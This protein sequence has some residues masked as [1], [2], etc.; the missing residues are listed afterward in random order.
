MAAFRLIEEEGTWDFQLFSGQF[1]HFE[2]CI[3]LHIKGTMKY[4][5]DIKSAIGNVQP[6]AQYYVIYFLVQCMNYCLSK[7][8][9]I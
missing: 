4:L 8:I 5:P 3:H 9:M 1:K 6:L 7:G 2:R